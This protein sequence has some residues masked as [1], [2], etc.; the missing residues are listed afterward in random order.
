MPEY[1]PKSAQL[2]KIMQL[3]EN[4]PEAAD[5]FVAR[6]EQTF[7]KM[8]SN[9]EVINMHQRIINFAKNSHLAND[10]NSSAWS[11]RMPVTGPLA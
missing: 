6:F 8:L 7:S 1:M 3:V 10:D 2:A 5:Y 4:S 11:A 9:P